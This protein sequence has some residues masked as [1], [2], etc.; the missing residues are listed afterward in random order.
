MLI[1]TRKPGES[2]MIEESV[3]ITVLEVRGS[4]VKLGIQAPLD[5]RV[6]R[7]EVL[8]RQRAEAGLPPIADLPAPPAPRQ[9]V[10]AEMRSRNARD[11]HSAAN[12][13]RDRAEP[14]RSDPAPRRSSGSRRVSGAPAGQNERGGSAGG[15]SRR[16][17]EYAGRPPAEHLRPRR[18]SENAELRRRSRPRPQEEAE[19]FTEPAVRRYRMPDGPRAHRPGRLSDRFG[20]PRGEQGPATPSLDP[21]QAP[22]ADD[23]APEE[24]PRRS[25]RSGGHEAA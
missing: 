21:D 20:K 3:R 19:E 14:A 25:R 10:L 12:G 22:L 2:V 6:N 1:L 7:E 17:S 5:V 24:A 4:Q 13:R 18:G 9:V 23:N 15:G 11:Q 8:E 16:R